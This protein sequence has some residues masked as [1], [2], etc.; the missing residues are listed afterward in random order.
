MYSYQFNRALNLLDIRWMGLFNRKLVATYAAA[1][2]EGFLESGFAPGYLLRMD[3][4]DSVVQSQEG[5]AAFRDEFIDFPKAARIAVVTESTIL[6][7]QIRREMP[8]SYLRVVA[9]PEA[10]LDWLFHARE[11]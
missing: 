3:M 4:R 7:L 6:R 5:L 9:T 2:R 1:L 10:A 11:P 8:Q